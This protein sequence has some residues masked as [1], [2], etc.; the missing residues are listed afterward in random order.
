MVLR[1]WLPFG[2]GVHGMKEKRQSRAAVVKAAV[3]AT[4]QAPP[5]PPLEYVYQ[6]VKSFVG[7]LFLSSGTLPKLTLFVSGA[8]V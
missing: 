3:A 1:S 5:P 8:A 2:A 6:T 7:Y 4:H